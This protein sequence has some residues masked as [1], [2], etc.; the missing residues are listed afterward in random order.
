MGVILS[1]LVLVFTDEQPPIRERKT[2]NPHYQTQKYDT[3]VVSHKC[4]GKTCTNNSCTLFVKYTLTAKYLQATLEG[5]ISA[6]CDTCYAI[7][8]LVLV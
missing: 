4:Y 8:T 7:L 3:G 1:E 2:V 6:L 5:L